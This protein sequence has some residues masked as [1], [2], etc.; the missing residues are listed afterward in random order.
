MGDVPP[1]SPVSRDVEQYAT[2]VT[3]MSL[4]HPRFVRVR[5]LSVLS[6]LS[7]KDRCIRVLTAVDRK[8]GF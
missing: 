7:S 6:P 4:D 3:D 2:C 8:L 5:G 1:F